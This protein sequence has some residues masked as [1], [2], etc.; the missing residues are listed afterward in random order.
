VPKRKP[1][2]EY[3]TEVFKDLFQLRWDEKTHSLSN[4]DVTLDEVADAIRQYRE[5]TGDDGARGDNNPANFFVDFVNNR[6]SANQR[7][8]ET[9]RVHGYTARQVTREG[10]AF[11]F[12]PLDR[13]SGE[14]FPEATTGIPLP[15]TETPRYQIET[16]SL[17]VAMRQ[18][19]RTDE[20]TLIQ[21]LVRLRVIETHL[22]LFSTRSI[23]HMEHVQN[24]LKLYG[25]E[26][27]ALFLVVEEASDA[28][29]EEVVVCCEVKARDKS[30]GRD[31]ILREVQAVFRL[32]NV[33]QNTVIPMAVKAFAP[34]QVQVV[35][36]EAVT[37]EDAESLDVLNIVSEA[38]YE[39]K[40][41]I[42]GIGERPKR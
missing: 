42:P 34:S 14:P 32:P 2:P 5:R 24:N 23:V 22:S 35:E 27:D 29:S 11:T 16:I 7:W 18:L 31:Q 4:P 10:M 6:P 1:R 36:F 37:R 15:R 33:K 26:I 3:K 8:P 25:S 39:F 38:V 13:V 28:D 12:I 20:P 9:V 41:R 17:P 30:L 19:G 40:P 21:V